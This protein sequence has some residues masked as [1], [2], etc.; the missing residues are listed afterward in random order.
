MTQHPRAS[1]LTQLVRA[2]EKA[3]KRVR[4]VEIE[5][6]DVDGRETPVWR[7]VTDDDAP[8]MASKIEW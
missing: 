2:V 1:S 8:K 5:W 4:S 7:I 3:G 6:R